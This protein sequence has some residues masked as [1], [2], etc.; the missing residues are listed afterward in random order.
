MVYCPRCGKKNP[1][2]NRFCTECGT[3]LP[4]VETPKEAGVKHPLILKEKLIVKEKPQKVVEKEKVIVV[5]KK[6]GKGKWIAAIIILIVLGFLGYR[7]FTDKAALDSLR[8]NV[9]GAGAPSIGF[10]SASIPLTLSI[11]NPSGNESPPCT[12]T[13]DVFLSGTKVASGSASVP[14]I[15]GGSSRDTSLTVSISYTS[16]GSAIWNI[17]SSG[18]FSLTIN[19]RLEAKAAFGII[20]I[21][22]SF[23]S[24]Y[25]I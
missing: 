12:L 23:S 15:S 20:P 4:M 25:T 21:S 7:Y 16:V 14:S 9:S 3:R 18:S 24:H 5:E 10:T 19:G 11:E 17:I 13:Y 1:D 22:K 6:G 2:E 8:A